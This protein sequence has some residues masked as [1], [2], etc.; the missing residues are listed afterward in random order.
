MSSHGKMEH[1]HHFDS[2]EHEFEAGKLG[3]WL[4]L[5][6]EIMTFGGLFVAFGIYHYLYPE[7]F[8]EAHHHLNKVM[9]AFNTVV[10]LISSLTMALAIA[11]IQ[12]DNP[13]RAKQMLIITFLC[14]AT[15]LVVKYFEYSAKF[16]HGLL[17]GKFFHG[18]GFEASNAAMFF[19]LYFVM[20]GIHGLHVLIGMGLM[21]WIYYRINRGDFNSRQYAAVEFV[22]LFWHIVDLIWIYLFPLLYLVV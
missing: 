11:F 17:P 14:A 2:I 15:F 8:R 7:M 22:G 16:H 3:M 19:S 5:V 9:G 12:R 4:F 10:L 1:A 13:K 21:A 6:T 18:E 20:T